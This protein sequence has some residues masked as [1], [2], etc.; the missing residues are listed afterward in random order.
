MKSNGR[1]GSPCLK[2][3]VA[4]KKDEGPPFY[5]SKTASGDACLNPFLPFHI[6]AHSIKHV[7][8]EVSRNMV[9]SLL[10]IQ[11]A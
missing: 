3:L 8:N 4:V 2:L 6:E 11:F 9:K 1:K 7:V 10:H 5:D